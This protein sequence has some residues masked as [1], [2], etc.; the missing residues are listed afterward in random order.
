MS[1]RKTGM[2]RHMNTAMAP[3]FLNQSFARSTSLPFSL[4]HFPYLSTKRYKRVSETSLL[5]SRA[6][7]NL[8]TMQL[9]KL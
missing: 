4:I 2:K 8:S 1:T 7:V 3:Y 5:Y 9:L 6:Q